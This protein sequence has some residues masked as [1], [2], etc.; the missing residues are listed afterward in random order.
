MNHPLRYTLILCVLVSSVLLVSYIT[1]SHAATL[2]TNFF[3]NTRFWD[4]VNS[5]KPEPAL[6]F[7]AALV[8]HHLLAGQLISQIFE[9]IK[10]QS[11]KTLI[12]V[13]PNH[14]ETGNFDI[15][16][17]S[18][19]WQTNFGTV[20]GTNLL[21]EFEPMPNT[22]LTAEHSV[23]GL[24]PYVAYYLP[25]TR[26]FAITLKHNTNPNQV[27]QLAKHIAD[28]L[29]LNTTLLVSVDFSHY[30]PKHTAEQRDM[31]TR[32]ILLSGKIEKLRALNNDYLD[33]PPSI[34]LLLEVCKLQAGTF[35]IKDHSNSAVLLKDAS[36]LSTTSYFTG[37]C[38]RP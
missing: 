27:S 6:A 15:Q 31:L 23:A 8:P 32:Q 17:G 3:E 29:G 5:A 10:Q 22:F 20:Y 14:Y 4:G 30:L 37:Y 18:T 11:P 38:A 19:N 34:A 7:T 33:S 24:I 26:V 13:G 16:S 12:I 2:P 9:E 28:K 35:I 36:L 25:K 1:R 21:P